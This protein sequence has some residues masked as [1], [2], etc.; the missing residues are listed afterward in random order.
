MSA[1]RPAFLNHRFLT[2]S[3]GSLISHNSSLISGFA[4]TALHCAGVTV[5]NPL[6]SSEVCSRQSLHGLHDTG[7]TLPS[8]V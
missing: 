1:R 6:A 3:S 8:D 5:E 2:G 4:M 7:V